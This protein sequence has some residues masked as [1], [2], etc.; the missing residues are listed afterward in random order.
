MNFIDLLLTRRSIRTYNNKE[1]SNDLLETI[2]KCGMY[3]PSARNQQ[4]WHFIVVT[5]KELLIQ[6]IEFLPNGKMLK[7]AYAAILVCG[8]E[9]LEKS[10]GYWPTDCAAATQNILLAAHALNI[11]SVWLGVY[12]RKER[13]EALKKLFTLPESIHPFSLISLGYT[14]EKVEKP[15]RFNKK[16]IYYNTFTKIM[17][18]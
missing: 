17:D 7:D 10:K 11:G 12:P 13:Q 1:I 6:M 8:D 15:D 14:D 3:A 18:R 2:I 5:E 4:A 9:E 16:R